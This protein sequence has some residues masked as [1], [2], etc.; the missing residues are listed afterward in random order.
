M[1]EFYKGTVEYGCP[2][3]SHTKI[4]CSFD[5]H[6]DCYNWIFNY[7]RSFYLN[8]D[9]SNEPQWIN[10]FIIHNNHR[11]A[12]SIGHCESFIRDDSDRIIF[13]KAAT[14]NNTNDSKKK[15]KKKITKR[16]QQ[17]YLFW[18][19]GTRSILATYSTAIASDLE[20]NGWVRLRRDTPFICSKYFARCINWFI[21][22]DNGKGNYETI[23]TDY[24]H[25]SN[26]PDEFK[27]YVRTIL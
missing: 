14:K 26:D 19:R 6:M 17:V 3:G 22:R 8:M 5:N 25:V 23:K 13:D 9:S 16:A 20:R 21:A 10:C 11:D 24:N 7:M 27:A 18:N 4:D 2:D 12:Y 1:S 15:M